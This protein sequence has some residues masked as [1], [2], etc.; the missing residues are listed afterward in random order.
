MSTN[1]VRDANNNTELFSYW[2]EKWLLAKN[3]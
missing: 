2:E 1:R 3:V